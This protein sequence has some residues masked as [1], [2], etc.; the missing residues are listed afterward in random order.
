MK[1]TPAVL[2]RFA[3]TETDFVIQ[4]GLVGKMRHGGTD[5]SNL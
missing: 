2:P 1:T 4:P 3:N 5:F